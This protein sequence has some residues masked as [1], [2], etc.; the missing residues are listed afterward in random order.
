MIQAMIR[1]AKRVAVLVPGIIITYFVVRDLY[2]AINRRIPAA[3][4]I[5][6]TYII[7][8]YILIPFAMRLV[9]IFV[10]PK[11]IPLYCTTPDGFACDPINIALV[12]TRQE[13][14]TAMQTAGWHLADS[15]S[16]K[17][18]FH[19]L[20]SL[21]FNKP[22]LNAPFSRLY[23]LGR[24]QDLGF[25]LPIGSSPRQR[26]HVRFWA[27][28]YTD[29]PR[30]EEHVDFWQR[31]QVARTRHRIMWVGAI[32]RDI[33]IR[34]VRHTAQLTHMVDPDTN[35]ERELLVKQLRR[36]KLVSNSRRVELGSPYRLRNRVL[37]G[38]MNADGKMTILEL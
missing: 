38:Y 7:T 14:M 30:Y 23:L 22:Y 3:L 9:R 34:P 24:S 20:V 2:P 6:L 18:L 25:Q 33:G 37:G 4:A 29:H 10:K 15:P 19:E 21:I 1:F 16:L 11:H 13:V 5:L 32:S 12:G 28:S 35:A 31:Q 27:A 26:H 17:N 36:T 8:A